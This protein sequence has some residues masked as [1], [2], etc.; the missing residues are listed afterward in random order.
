[1]NLP[2]VMVLAAGLGTRMR[3]LTDTK[4][5][6]LI[7]VGSV[8]LLDR[9]LGSFATAGVTQ[10]VVNTHYLPDQIE[11][12]CGARTV[13]P[14]VTLSPE[15]DER[16]ETG[17]GVAKAL[18]LLGDTFFTTNADS[19]WAGDDEAVSRLHAVFDPA[20]MDMLLLLAPR[21]ESVGL[22]DH[23]GD[24][25]MDAD[26]RLERRKDNPVSWNYTGTAIM[27]A[28]LFGD[29]PD[30]PFSLNVLFDRALAEGRLFGLPL[31]GLWLTVGTPDAITEAEQALLA[32]GH[33]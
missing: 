24:F 23:P 33:R 8:T 20:R 21:A 22:G 3:P 16:L 11:A 2:P 7:E 6:P 18:P 1:M 13:P 27:Q 28:S 29:V 9:V 10:A 17:G 14:A 4:P 5:K 31:K 30:G 19:F 12:H 26:G 15:P 25:S 32:A